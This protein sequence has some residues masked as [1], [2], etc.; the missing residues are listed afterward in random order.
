MSQARAQR[1]MGKPEAAPDW[2][3]FEKAR[4]GWAAYKLKEARE[5]LCF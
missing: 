1:C 5:M 3:P 4:V 2:F